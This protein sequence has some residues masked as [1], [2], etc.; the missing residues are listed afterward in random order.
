MNFD[1]TR[2]GILLVGGISFLL[3]AAAC[4]SDTE[5]EAPAPTPRPT[6]TTS[7]P[8]A[9]ATAPTSI[10][11]P[12]PVTE[13]SESTSNLLVGNK[14][15]EHVPEFSIMLGDGSV[16]RSTEILSD[17]KPVFIFFWATWCSVC[18]AE[19]QEM[20]GVYPE[21]EDDVAFYAVGQ[22]PTESVSLLTSAAED[23]NYPWPVASAGP[24][25]LRTL[26]IFSQSS[27]LAFTIDGEITYKAG[28]GQGNADA[29]RQ[30][31]EELVASN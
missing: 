22:D 18:R 31:F 24:G 21:F 3:I 1:N 12:A 16:K 6:A 28:Y 4:S 15:G 8:A 30:V 26:N 17:G 29:W 25:M 20:L 13:T 19:L 10:P 14:V 11:T 7:A 23:R 9:Q 5:P 2:W 27:K